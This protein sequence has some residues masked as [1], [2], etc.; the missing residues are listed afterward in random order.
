MASVTLLK[1]IEAYGET[2]RELT[3]REPTA[4]DFRACGI[5]FEIV[6]GGDDSGATRLHFDA[7]AVLGLIAKL[8]NVP[9]STIDTLCLVDFMACQAVVLGFFGD[10]GSG[11]TSSTGITTSPGN[12]KEITIESS[13]SRSRN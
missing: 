4:K 5:P 1:P 11:S 12:G 6:A 7:S 10:Q 2:V 8:T 3:F 13:S 9:P